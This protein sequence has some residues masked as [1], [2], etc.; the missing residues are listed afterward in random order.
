MTNSYVLRNISMQSFAAKLSSI[1]KIPGLNVSRDGFFRAAFL[2]YKLRMDAE[3]ANNVAKSFTEFAS[4]KAIQRQFGHSGYQVA[5][6]ISDSDCDVG[7]SSSSLYQ[8]TSPCRPNQSPFRPIEIPQ[9][10]S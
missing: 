2:L 8:G 7:V 1:W 9:Y 6:N 10:P 3:S 4:R 5:A